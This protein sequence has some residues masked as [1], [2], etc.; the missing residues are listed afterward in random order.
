MCIERM[1]AELLLEQGSMKGLLLR[2]AQQ[3][4]TLYMQAQHVQERGVPKLLA[5]HALHKTNEQG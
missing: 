5:E 3:A 2:Q 1:L 4:K